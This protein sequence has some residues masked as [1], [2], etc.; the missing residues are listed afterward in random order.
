M[1]IGDI[2]G[3]VWCHG[4]Y[5]K[6][7]V[8]SLTLGWKFILCFKIAYLTDVLGNKVPFMIM[9]MYTSNEINHNFIEIYNITIMMHTEVK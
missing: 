7:S 6:P 5:V 2:K 9:K 8:D 3:G 1:D 4:A